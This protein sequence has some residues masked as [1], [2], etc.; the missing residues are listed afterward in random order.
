MG[1]TASRL[2]AL[3]LVFVVIVVACAAPIGQPMAAGPGDDRRTAAAEPSGPSRL[4]VATGA[5]IS[6]L[7][8]KLDTLT[9]SFIYDPRYMVNTPL[10]AL[11]GQNKAHAL[12]AAELPARDRGTWVV[13]P[14]GTMATTWQIRANALWHDG[15]AVTSRDFIFA[16]Q[17]YL[18]PDLEI[19]GRDLEL[20]IDRIESIDEQSFIIHWKQLHLRADRLLK[21]E[22]EPLPE[23]LARQ[24]YED[25]DKAGFS[26]APLWTSAA[27]VGTG[28]YRIAEWEKGAQVV[29]RAFDRYVLGRPKIDEV[30]FRVVSDPNTAVA[31]V[32]GGAIDFTS[33]IVL[34]TEA[35]AAVK[36][37]WDRTG[38][39]RVLFVPAVL[40]SARIQHHPARTG[41]P[42]LLDVRVR[43]ALVHGIDRETL[44]DVISGGTSPVADTIVTPS[45]PLYP[46]VQ[47][48]IAKYRYD[49]SRSLALLQEAGWTRRADTLVNAGG[50]AFTLEVKGSIAGN[51]PIEVGIIASDLRKLGMR[52]SENL[53]RQN[54]EDREQTVHFPGINAITSSNMEIPT[55]LRAYAADQCPTADRRWVGDNTGC[56]INPEFER[57]YRIATT[58]L[59][60]GERTQAVLAALKVLTEEVGL[61]ALSYNVERVAV[62]KGLVGPGPRSV[63]QRGYTWNI[64]E[65]RWE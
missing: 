22:L 41:Q 1:R 2:R 19:A 31:H 10:V 49:P 47:G 6:N 40:R 60:E 44:A 42:A 15:R 12:L 45:D 18:D 21:G 7:A 55:G 25:G 23:H 35:G 3:W 11:D 58:T 52:A 59:D 38:G 46:R 16:L 20:L 57:L 48:V 53:V 37:E 17:V 32:L 34:N 39:G 51:I 24:L 27:Y 50:E 4:V 5:D 43:R 54:S 64:H 29:Y 62:R 63:I 30:I 28:P 56:W 14:D 65:W 13:N 61:I 36:Q 9:G 8:T 33:A 26:T